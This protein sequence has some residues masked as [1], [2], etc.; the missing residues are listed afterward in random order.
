MRGRKLS[1]K[2]LAIVPVLVAVGTIFGAFPI[3]TDATSYPNVPG[4]P[5]MTLQLQEPDEEVTFAD[6][7]LEAAIRSAISKQSGPIYTS[8]LDVLTEL[9]AR[10]RS[11]VDLTGLEHCTSL[12]RLYLDNNEISDIS[13]L[14]SL[15]SLR[16]LELYHNQISDISP[17]SS[18]TSLTHLRLYLNQIGD[19]SPLSSLTSLTWLRL[20]HNQIS[21]I[22]PLSSLTSLL[23]LY[24]NNNQIGDISPLSSLTSLYDLYLE[25]NQIGDISPLSSL[26]SLWRLYLEDNQISDIRPL[27][28]NA[29]VSEG[30]TVDVR[31]NPLSATSIYIYIPQLEARG[32][33]VLYT[34]SEWD[35]WVYDENKDG[36]IQ[37]IEAIHAV[38][39]Y[40]AGGITKAQAIEV[41]SLYPGQ[42]K[43]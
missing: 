13:P 5:D 31:D 24:L 34:P 40:F 38:Q 39:R 29:G 22:S 18:L 2:L 30:D 15:T 1:S 3:V 43:D 20:D 16:V 14:S 17:L 10:H 9:G 8:D 25:D 27:V 19:I 36:K 7:N 41:V 37:R 26:T 23:L 32:V 12:T 21:D 28:D 33:E 11:I 6:P 42:T 35:P 4:M